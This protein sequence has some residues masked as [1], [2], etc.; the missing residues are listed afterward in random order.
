MKIIKPP[1]IM[2]AHKN[3]NSLLTYP[4][5]LANKGFAL[6]LIFNFTPIFSGLDILPDVFLGR[7]LY[8]N[9]LIVSEIRYLFQLNRNNIAH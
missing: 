7:R 5:G 6:L 9:A 4:T 8:N 2:L 3:R 1:E